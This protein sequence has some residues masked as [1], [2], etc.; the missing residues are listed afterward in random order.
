MNACAQS[1]ALHLAAAR[2]HV[3]VVRALLEVKAD[4]RAADEVLRVVCACGVR[5]AGSAVPA[6]WCA[7]FLSSCCWLARVTAMHFLLSTLF[8]LSCLAP[9]RIWAV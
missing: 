5:S 6:Q 9:P 3:A 8:L 1:T 4:L 7:L 2:G